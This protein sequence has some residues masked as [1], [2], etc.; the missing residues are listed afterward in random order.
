MFNGNPNANALSDSIANYLSDHAHFKSHGR[1]ISR[2]TAKS[3]GLIIQDLESDPVL[4]DL[5]LSIFHATTHTFTG[6]L[7]TKII[8]NHKGK[9]FIKVTRK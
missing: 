9:A 5:V 1:H 4:Q 7:A 6:T 8:E 3:Q 2:D